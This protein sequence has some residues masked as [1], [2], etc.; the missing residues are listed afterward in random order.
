L[1]PLESDEINGISS[2]SDKEESHDVEIE[3]AP[4][5]LEN[6]VGV[7]SDKHNQVQFLSLVGKTNDVFGRDYFEQE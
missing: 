1:R 7:S 5:V 6:H 2:D 3:G 4:V